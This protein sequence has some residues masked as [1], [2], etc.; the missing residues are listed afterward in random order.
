METDIRSTEKGTVTQGYFRR[1]RKPLL[2][3]KISCLYVAA[4]E[5]NAIF[6][7]THTSQGLLYGMNP[8]LPRDQFVCIITYLML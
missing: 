5:D 3:Q 1:P 2:F 7:T 6:W 8:S 4:L